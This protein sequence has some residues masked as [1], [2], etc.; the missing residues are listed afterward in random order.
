MRA[1]PI[2]TSRGVGV[3][4]P[5]YA[6]HFLRSEAYVSSAAD[7]KNLRVAETVLWKERPEIGTDTEQAIVKWDAGKK[8]RLCL[9]APV[10]CLAFAK[11]V[12][13]SLSFQDKVLR[14]AGIL[15]L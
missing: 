11:H 3:I 12:L 7:L 9:G 5:E 10:F 6:E 1:P 15:G 13:Q 2:C 4:N 8:K 14:H